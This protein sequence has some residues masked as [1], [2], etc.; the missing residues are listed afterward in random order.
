ME[1]LLN[2][3]EV[4]LPV[5]PIRDGIVFPGTEM[6]L[7]FGRQRSVS[8]IEAGQSSAKRVILVMQRNPNVNDP[9]P[10]DLYNIA[11]VGEIVQMMKNEGEI[12]ALVRGVSKVEILSYEAIEPF[13]VARAITIADTIEEDEEMKALFNHLTNELRQAVKLGKTMDFLTFMNIMSGVSPQ[14]LSYQV[15]GVLDIKPNERQE[16]LE[17]VSVKSRLEKEVTYLSR[18]VKIL[19]LE[20]K[21]ANKTQEKFDKNV[22]EQ[23]LRERMK[24]IEKELGEDDGN[25]EYK[26]LA[27]KIK[28][29]GMPADVRAKAE[30]ELAR[31]IQMSQYNPE[32]SYVR[33]YLDWLV[34]LPWGVASPNNVI[35][36]DAERILNHDH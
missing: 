24:T 20:K 22:R 32:S 7:T 14:V 31:L 1:E 9:T 25:K 18:E 5:V 8:A 26:E 27:D 34:E 36:S 10:S 33:A 2:P 21:I 30:K 13:F 16:L 28:K 35:I 23:V 6:I 4:V 15:A 12:N 19:E 3:S 29:A 17:L 11:T